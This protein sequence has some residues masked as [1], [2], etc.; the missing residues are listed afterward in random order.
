M[1]QRR[2]DHIRLDL[3]CESQARIGAP[4]QSDQHKIGPCHTDV[5]ECAVEGGH[6][7]QVEILTQRAHECQTTMSFGLDQYSLRLR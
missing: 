5:S 7:R 2:C 3:A 4:P 1:K 6:W